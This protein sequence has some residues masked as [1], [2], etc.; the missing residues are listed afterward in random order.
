MRRRPND[1]TTIVSVYALKRNHLTLRDKK[2][3][4]REHGMTYGTFFV[5]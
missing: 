1:N 2:I 3:G 5:L 4:T